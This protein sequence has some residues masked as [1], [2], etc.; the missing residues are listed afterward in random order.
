M[1]PTAVIH[2]SLLGMHVW[3][4]THSHA[5]VASATSHQQSCWQTLQS[6]FT[7]KHHPHVGDLTGLSSTLR[8]AQTSTHVRSRSCP[9]TAQQSPRWSWQVTPPFPAPSSCLIL[10]DCILC[11]LKQ[12]CALTQ[13]TLDNVLLLTSFNLVNDKHCLQCYSLSPLTQ[14]AQYSET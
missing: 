1:Y 7:H 10:C 5:H 13:D 6:V 4:A 2:H 9:G 11:E 12:Q 14:P 3:A 8:A